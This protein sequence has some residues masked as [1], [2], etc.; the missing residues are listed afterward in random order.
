MRKSLAFIFFILSVF[1][2]RASAAVGSGRGQLH[3]IFVSLAQGQYTSAAARYLD[4]AEWL[5][6]K[7]ASEAT[8]LYPLPDLAEAMILARPVDNCSMI[9]V[10]PWQA[11]TLVRNV[12]VR[13][14]GISGANAFLGD[15]RIGLSVD[16]IRSLV[17]K[18]LVDYTVE[19]DN[20][21]AYEQL[22]TVLDPSNPAYN[23]VR[24]RMAK[25]E[26][27]RLCTSS[28]GCMAFLRDYSDSPYVGKAQELK[29]KFDFE[30]AQRQGTA[31][32]WQRFINAYRHA[33]NA[34]HL[35]ERATA[36]C[37]A[38]Q[39]NE[40]ANPNVTLAQ[41]DH[42]AS[43]VR[44]DPDDKILVVYD[45]IINLP[46]SSYRLRS[47]QLSFDGAVGAVTESVATSTGKR[48][49]TRFVFNQQGLLAERGKAR[50]SYGFDA[51]HGFYPQSRTE[52]GKT[53]RYTCSYDAVGGRLS[54]L[55][56]TDGSEWAFAYDPQGHITSIIET[57]G[58]VKRTSTYRS[59]KIRTLD[60]TN[61][62]S[63]KFLRY[64]GTRVTQIDM[65]KKNAVTS[66]KIDYQPDS[67]QS[68]WT[69]A[70]VQK[71]G[72]PMLTVTRQYAQ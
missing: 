42:Y 66:L 10:D 15:D 68:H 17:E 35:V 69:K 60:S 41:L 11:M 6:S 3:D 54:R 43:T 33:P 49:S 36:L 72:A 58:G 30:D 1:A 65:V 19:L 63:M 20:A 57:Q 2:V 31:A 62:M 18:R 71:N 23:Q 7:P 14:E 46:M 26:F 44:R 5:R 29:A 51:A 55:V 50:Y 16:M 64:D 52:G 13:D 12:Y 24:Q 22:M 37:A 59:G 47:N 28:S 67:T 32:A 48:T 45:N 25:L 61:K 38:A 9:V 34:Q 21:E 53:Y 56:C 27:D 4:F 8:E 70:V 39:K 40:L